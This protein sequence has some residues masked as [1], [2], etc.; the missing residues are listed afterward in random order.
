V[1]VGFCSLSF[2]ALTYFVSRR[3]TLLSSSHST[4][5]PV[6]AVDLTCPDE[7]P[8]HVP[9]VSDHSSEQAG[10]AADRNVRLT[11]PRVLV[12]VE[13]PYTRLGKTVVA[14]LQSVRYKHRVQVTSYGY[15]TI[16]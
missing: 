15:F 10:E 7:V 2:V 11:E 9:V 8:P 5:T 3:G 1:A 16:N 14:M 6:T 12:V 4:P 13:T